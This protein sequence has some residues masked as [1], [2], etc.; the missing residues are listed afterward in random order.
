MG[1]QR[2]AGRPVCMPAQMGKTRV[3][4]CALPEASARASGLTPC[5][6]PAP[7]PSALLLPGRSCS[8]LR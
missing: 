1:S 5:C 4:A 2:A 7:A 6:E 8:C 3:H